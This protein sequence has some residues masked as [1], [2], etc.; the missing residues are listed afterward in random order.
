MGSFG[1]GFD[2]TLRVAETGSFVQR[3]LLGG[4]CRRFLRLVNKY[5]IIS[6]GPLAVGLEGIDAEEVAL[7]LISFMHSQRISSFEQCRSDRISLSIQFYQFRGGHNALR[8]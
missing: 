8:C 4:Q 1:G 2:P 5:S 3:D 6:Y 7:H